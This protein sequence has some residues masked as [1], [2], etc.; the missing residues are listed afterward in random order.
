MSMIAF[1]GFF[2]CTLQAFVCRCTALGMLALICLISSLQFAATVEQ[3]WWIRALTGLIPMTM[4]GFLICRTGQ[5]DA[6]YLGRISEYRFVIIEASVMFILH[7]I[8]LF[9]ERRQDIH[10]YDT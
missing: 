10:Q 6:L 4:L 7:L 1:L 8:N 9:P 3:S 5:L 2:L